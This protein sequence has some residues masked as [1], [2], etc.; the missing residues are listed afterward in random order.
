VLVKACICLVVDFI[1]I[2]LLLLLMSRRVIHWFDNFPLSH[3]DIR[4]GTLTYIGRF[5]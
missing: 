5:P 3:Y 1:N 4:L 2:I